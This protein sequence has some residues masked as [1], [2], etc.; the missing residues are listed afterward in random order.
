MLALLSFMKI[1]RITSFFYV[2]SIESIMHNIDKYILISIYIFIVKN[3]IKVFCRIYKKIHFINN[4]KTYIL[5]NNDIINLK[6][7]VLNVV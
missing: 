1:R 7:I 6:K 3:N 5:L 4:L 2:K